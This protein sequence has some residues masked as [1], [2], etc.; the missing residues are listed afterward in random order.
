L[1]YIVNNASPDAVLHAGI[2][3]ERLGQPLKSER[4][5]SIHGVDAEFAAPHYIAVQHPAFNA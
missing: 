2:E 3:S 1:G 4:A 5:V